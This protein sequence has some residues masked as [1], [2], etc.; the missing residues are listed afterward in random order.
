LIHEL[1]EW[2]IEG[3]KRAGRLRVDANSINEAAAVVTN[4]FGDEWLTQACT[5][6]KG[7]LW[8]RKHPLGNLLIPPGDN[9]IVEMLELVE[10]LKAAALSPVFAD[11]VAGLRAQYGPTFLQLAWAYRLLRLGATNLAFEPPVQRGQK[12]DLAFGLAG[13]SIVAECYIP[14]VRGLNPEVHWLLQHCLDV[15]EGFHPAI[16]SIAIKLKADPTAHERKVILRLVRE[17]SAEIDAAVGHSEMQSHFVQTDAAYISVAPTRAAAPD[18]YSQG[19]Q[20]PRFPDMR[21]EEPFVFGRIS[22][23]KATQLRAGYLPAP[24]ETR[25]HVAIWLSDADAQAHSLHR[26]LDEPLRELGRKLE[27][28]LGQTRLD[29]QT[30]RLLIVSSWIT[31]ELRRASENAIGELRNLLFRKH[32]GVAGVLLV[33]HTYRSSIERPAY[34]FDALLP[35]NAHWFTWDHLTQLRELERQSPVPKVAV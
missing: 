33:S 35:D 20:D 7:G 18:E 3:L 12:G 25:D 30:G 2:R 14:R 34:E 1:D 17:L 5:R 28:K 21:G 32:R 26:D 19:M 23:G 15:R 9:Q 24:I 11:L 6:D 8:M 16:V 31:R 29:A 10:Y 13:R 4:V 22:V 27:R